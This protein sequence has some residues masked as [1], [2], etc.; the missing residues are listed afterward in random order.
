MSLSI[1]L[2]SFRV[3]ACLSVSE[4]ARLRLAA[5]TWGDFAFPERGGHVVLEGE[6]GGGGCYKENALGNGIEPLLIVLQ[7]ELGPPSDGTPPQPEDIRPTQ[8]QACFG[9][10]VRC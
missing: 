5:T 4:R 1:F 6:V 9:P 10:A 3:S 2:K 8:R 7:S